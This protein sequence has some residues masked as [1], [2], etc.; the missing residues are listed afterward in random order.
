[1]PSQ[2]DLFQSRNA[3]EEKSVTHP[4]NA[5]LQRDQVTLSNNQKPEEPVTYEHLKNSATTEG[6]KT[7]FVEQ[8]MQAMLNRRLGVDS[9]K[10]KALDEEIAALEKQDN[11][12]D[13]DKAKLE[14]LLEQKEALV[15]AAAERLTAERAALIDEQT[16]A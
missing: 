15:K 5:V 11:L 2:Y 7:S 9:E 12:S 8:A 1:M 6:D 13:K 14:S 10:L 3:S 4:D 16:E